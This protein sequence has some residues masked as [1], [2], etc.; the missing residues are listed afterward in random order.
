MPIN[1]DLS[2]SPYFDDHDP[3]KNYYKVLFKPGVAPQVRELNQLQT[4]LQEQVERF[5]NNIYKRG[6]IIDGIN[7]IYYPSYT[8]VK[9]NDSQLDGQPAVPSN[10]VSHFV[11]DPTSN[12]TAHIIN[13]V[14]GFESTDPDLKTLYLRYINSG[15]SGNATAFNTGS[16]LKIYDYLDS[17]HKVL[18]TNGSSGFSNND[19]VVFC[20]ALDITLSTN[21]DF[22]VGETI[23]Q[24]GNTKY[25]IVT[26]TGI[27][28]GK[29]VLQIRPR[30]TDLSNTAVSSTIW[31]F[32]D[33]ED[34]IG[35][36]SGATA[37][38]NASVGAGAAATITTTADIGKITEVSIVSGGEGYYVSPYCS[39]KSS[40]ASSTIGTRNYTDLSLT[41]QNYIAQITV[42]SKANTVGSGYA[43]GVTEG[44]IYQKGY[45]VQVDP[46]TV[47]ISKHSPSPDGLSVGFDT[48]EEVVDSNV[49]QDLLDNATGQPNEFAPGADRLKLT[50]RLIV[51]D[52]EEAQAND[53]F[54][55]LADFSEGRAYK[56]NRR[57]QFNS[58]Q[59]EMAIRT[60]ESSGDYVLNEFLVTTRSPANTANEGK[61]FSVVVDPGKGYIDGYRIE[62]ISN[63]YVDVDKGIDTRTAANLSATIDYGNY[64]L[65]TE[66]AGLWNCNVGG[67]INLKDTATAFASNTSLVVAGTLTSSGS[68]IGTARIRNLVWES[69]EPGTPSAVYR[70]YLFNIAMLAGKNFTGVKGVQLGSTTAVADAVQTFD[71]TLNATVCRL[72]DISKGST[73]LIGTGDDATASVANLSYIYRMTSNTLSVA[74]TGSTSLLLTDSAEYFGYETTSLTTTEKKS[75]ILVPQA[76]IR[77]QANT[78]IDGTA[79]ITNASNTVTVSSAAVNNY[80]VGDFLAL[81]QN[82]STSI[83]RRIT[84]KTA[85]QFQLDSAA[86]FTNATGSFSR[87]LPKNVPV[88]LHRISTATATTSGGGKTLNIFLGSTLDTASA[89][90]CSLTY[91][92]KVVGASPQSKTADRDNFVK[93]QITQDN[94]LGPWCLGIPDIFRLK[95]V[96]L[97]TSSGV[98]TTATDVTDQ[99]FID[100]NQ[101]SDYYGLGYLFKRTNANIILGTTHWLLVQFDAFTSSPGVY[102]CTS[103]VSSNT[104]QRFTDDSLALAS[105][106]TKTNSFEV[107][108]LYTSAGKY[109]DLINCI[110]FRP[111]AT[112]TASYAKT[113]ASATQNPSATL[114]FDGTDKKFPLPGAGVQFDRSGFLGRKDAVIVTKDNLITVVRGTPSAAPKNPTVPSGVLFLNR[115]AIPAYP[116]V[117]ANFSANNEGDS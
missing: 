62:T 6:T 1:K 110:D 103:Y 82:S 96:Y 95:K 32:T 98:D 115:L 5:G 20:S 13:S 70:L 55:S 65:V 30:T 100:H 38:I 27:V 45:F 97:G 42:S 46:Q 59:D 14:D 116:C 109:Y 81:Y 24:T 68:T 105:L 22:T 117:A 89:T 26:A 47:I 23:S 36:T 50:P 112:A 41:A 54:L 37:K 69:G 75:V 72:L 52:T 108:E 83:I 25:A 80:N 106:G 16:T 8:Y 57:T 77:F 60:K 76:D 71:A 39:I 88:G 78:T 10:Y 64:I 61:N 56:E 31:Q 29:K 9:I 11:V 107:P 104:T 113:A 18:I 86:T 90:T 58:I 79:A 99:F 33:G 84:G 111:I 28:N 40:G 85:T 2:V 43:F 4:I 93:V 66:V 53:E 94:L 63:Y 102:T 44:V 12:L 21:T 15:N 3:D 73:L 51:L 48:T 7:F 74:N 17:V 87:A 67:T 49:D 114:T 34:I 101:M 92:V 91:D 19:A 35:A